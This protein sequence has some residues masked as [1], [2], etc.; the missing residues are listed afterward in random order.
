M[1]LPIAFSGGHG[2]STR[3]SLTFSTRSEWSPLYFLSS[4][5]AGKAALRDQPKSSL[6]L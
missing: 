5:D 1:N 4:T 2:N 6:A 3:G